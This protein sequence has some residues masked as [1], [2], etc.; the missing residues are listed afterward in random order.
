MAETI[1]NKVFDRYRPELSF[2][3]VSMI[4]NN[5]NV[6]ITINYI[7]DEYEVYY[8]S[9]TTKYNQSRQDCGFSITDLFRNRRRFFFH[10]G[11]QVKIVVG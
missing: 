6:A 7:N 4:N 5:F 10:Y 2:K 1:S 9:G 8:N 11:L 3:I